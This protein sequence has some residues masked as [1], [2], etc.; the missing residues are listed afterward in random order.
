MSI[1]AVLAL[2]AC[3][4]DDKDKDE[5]GTGGQTATQAQKDALAFL[6]CSYAAYTSFPDEQSAEYQQAIGV[7][8]QSNL[9]IGSL[10]FGADG[11]PNNTYT[12]EL[13]A[14]VTETV[15]AMYQGQTA[16]AKAQSIAGIHYMILSFYQSLQ[17]AQ[18]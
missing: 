18:K 7:C 4:K 17:S 1:F 11:K 9:T 6:T 15:N 14:A 16:E 12:T 10:S 8:L 3:D 5:S 13:F 2:V